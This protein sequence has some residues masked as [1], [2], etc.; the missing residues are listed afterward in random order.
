MS[1][2][3]KTR[4]IICLGDEFQNLIYPD[5]LKQ[6]LADVI[7]SD[8]VVASREDILAS[9]EYLGAVEF[10]F[11]G[12]G[13]TTLDQALLDC[14]PKLNA[15]FSSAGGIDS[16]SADCLQQKNIPLFTA[17]EINAIPVVDYTV[18]MVLLSLKQVWKYQRAVASGTF[19][20]RDFAGTPGAYH[21]S[22]VG[23]V[24][25]GAIG[26]AVCER[27]AHTEVELLAY[28]PFVSA[29]EFERLGIQRMASLEHLFRQA[30]V[31]SI[32]LPDTKETRGLI[33]QDLLS[34]MPA[35][36]T[37]INSSRGAVINEEDL[38]AILKK[39][40]DLSAVLDV[41][42]D[43]SDFCATPLAKL[44]NVFL[45]PHIAGSM[46]NECRRLGEHTIHTC[47][48]FIENHSIETP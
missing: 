13:G 4:A 21:G 18:A 17:Q 39:R 1:D 30:H 27:L 35:N 24:S 44:P 34:H 43:E 31:V 26:R 20:S 42:T 28:D 45:T 16:V 14:L 6:Q 40:S 11:H 12:W 9:R 15:V 38:I 36:A 46:G 8:P 3:S 22:Q 5:A 7:S 48:A 29:G 41:I 33:N 25:L 32:H 23:I 19:Q 37:L 47:K 2:A 10:I